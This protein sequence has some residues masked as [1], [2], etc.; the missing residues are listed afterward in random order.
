MCLLL[1]LVI[2]STSK[3]TCLS[4]C[5]CSGF[6]WGSMSVAGVTGFPIKLNQRLDQCKS[7]VYRNEQPLGPQSMPTNNL[8]LTVG[9]GSKEK[10]EEEDWHEE[11]ER[12]RMRTKCPAEG[13]KTPNMYNQE[14]GRNERVE[15]N[16]ERSGL[17]GKHCQLLIV[18]RHATSCPLP[19]PP[20]HIAMLF[21]L[22]DHVMH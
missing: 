5:A 8:S 18:W 6:V 22:F 16:T 21:Y 2:H 9:P 3:S 12:E 15:L 14:D 17:S 4:K 7:S 13:E 10:E 11:K 19:T 1:P 20:H